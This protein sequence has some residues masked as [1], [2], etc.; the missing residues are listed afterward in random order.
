MEEKAKASKLAK[1][2]ICGDV[3]PRRPNVAISITPIHVVRVESECRMCTFK[4][5]ST[6]IRQ[7]DDEMIYLYHLR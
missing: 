6:R 4:R 3:D 1:S 5:V 2:Y 7:K